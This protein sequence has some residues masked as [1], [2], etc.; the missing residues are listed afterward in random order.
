[1]L[2]GVP[3]IQHVEYDIDDI[4]EFLEIHTHSS[5]QE[6]SRTL[7]KLLNVQD[8]I[9]IIAGIDPQDLQV[10][11]DKLEFIKYAFKDIII[12]EKDLSQEIFFILSGECHVFKENKKIGVIK[13]GKTFGEAAAIFNTKR[14][15]SVVCASKE[16]TLLSFRIEH[17]NMD[18]CAPALAKLYKNLALQ[19]NT[20]L[21]SMNTQ[22]TKK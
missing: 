15:A 9:S 17:E 1:M 12:K 6:Y 20:K 2:K 4:E 14:N 18:F 22:A 21:E 8:K 11:I 13:A 7:Q 3:M 16:A 19:I 10:I 5:E